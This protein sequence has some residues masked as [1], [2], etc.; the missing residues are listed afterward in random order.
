[1]LRRAHSSLSAAT[2]SPGGPG[3]YSTRSRASS[4]GSPGAS[5]PQG[6]AS[7]GW[8]FY[9]CNTPLVQSVWAGRRCFTDLA[10][11]MSGGRFCRS[12]SRDSRSCNTNVVHHVSS[13]LLCGN[14]LS[15]PQVAAAPSDARIGDVRLLNV[16]H[17]R[18]ANSRDADCQLPLPCRGIRQQPGLA[19]AFRLC[20][21][22]DVEALPTSQTSTTQNPEMSTVY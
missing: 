19:A 8:L 17:Q 6:A 22:R 7:T 1:M 13:V 12:S 10:F 20:N 16:A 18:N 15:R 9:L 21:M 3:S 11:G 2:A 14:A 4:V 5:L